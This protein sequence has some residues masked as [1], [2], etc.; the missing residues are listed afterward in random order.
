VDEVLEDRELTNLLRE[1]IEEL[2]PELNERERQ[3]LQERLLEDEP[4]TLQ[5]I[6]EEWGV[7]REAVRQMEARLLKKIKERFTSSL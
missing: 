5:D 1:K 3:L 4:K 6:G 2:K 7:T